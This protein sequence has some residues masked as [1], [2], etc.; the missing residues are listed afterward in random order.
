MGLKYNLLTNYTSFIAIDHIVRTKEGADTVNQ[1]LPLP[2]GVGELAIGAEVPST[3]EPEFYV[4][5]AVAG[6][7]GAYLRRRKQQTKN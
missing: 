6:G 1:P 4:M 7:L 5:L 2:Q 3:P